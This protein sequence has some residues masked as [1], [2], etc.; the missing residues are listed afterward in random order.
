MLCNA[1][2][3]I[4]HPRTSANVT[5][6]KDLH[7]NILILIL[8]RV[9]EEQQADGEDRRSYDGDSEQRLEHHDAIL[10]KAANCLTSA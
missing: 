9:W 3:M 6:D 4:L 8:I 5:Q 2:G 7:G 10:L 1:Q